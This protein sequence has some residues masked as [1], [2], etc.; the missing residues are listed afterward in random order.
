M[1]IGVGTDIVEVD[2]IRKAFSRRPEKFRRKILAA[3]EIEIT[4]V[5][6][7]IEYLAKRFAAKEAIS[8]VLGTGMQYG[9]SFGDILILTDLETGQPLV[10]LKGHAKQQ[11]SLKGINRILISISDEKDYA[12]AFAVGLSS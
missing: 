4:P 10:E 7:E 1:I 12:M 6:R 9:V 3:E 11:A 8:K 2:R 5:S